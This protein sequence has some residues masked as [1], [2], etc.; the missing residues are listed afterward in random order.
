MIQ[1]ILAVL[2]VLTLAGG[3][4]AAGPDAAITGQVSYRER[5]ALP[6]DAVLEVTLLDVSRADAAAIALSTRRYAM[7]G[8]PFAFRLAYD[9]ALIEDRRSYTIRARILSGDTVLF[10]TTRAHPVLT[11]GAGADLAITLQRAETE[12]DAAAPPPPPQGWWEAFE[13]AGRT[14]VTERRPQITF[15]VEPGTVALRGG[16]NRFA[17][18]AELAPGKLAFADGMAGT[19]MA[20]PPPY[21]RLEADFLT[22]LKQ[23]TGYAMERDLMA[24]TNAAG[25]PVMRLI[26]AE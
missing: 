24:L 23:V 3:L 6:P 5:I 8:V 18:K 4:Q 16:C 10:R 20:C 15:G 26:R 9:P 22:A 7:T 11:R 25:L 19:L 2:A 13:I 21:D 12:G 14:L 17:G 1:R